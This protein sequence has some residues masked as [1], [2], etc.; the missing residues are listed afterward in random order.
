MWIKVLH[1][2]AVISWM[3]GLLYLPRLFVYHSG[4][5]VKGEA[6]ELFK[7]MEWRLL[8]AIMNPASV[9]ALF[10]GMYLAF[11]MEVFYRAWFHVKFLSITALFLSHYFCLRFQKSFARDER[12]LS[13]KGFRIFNEVPTVLMLII[14]VAVIYKPGY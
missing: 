8:N 6:S 13:G 14:L 11:E 3:A 1:L 10:T 4:V 2:A 7:I 5:P 9:V 12:P